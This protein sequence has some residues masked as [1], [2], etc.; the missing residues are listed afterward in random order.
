MVERLGLW[1]MG[2]FNGQRLA[3]GIRVFGV[4]KSLGFQ[5][6]GNGLKGF[7]GGSGSRVFIRADK[8]M[9]WGL[10]CGRLGPTGFEQRGVR[11]RF[12]CVGSGMH[13]IAPNHELHV[14]LALLYWP[15]P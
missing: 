3:L 11:C 10:G 4:G 13:L 9:C 7:S 5:V 12:R 14:S 1:A 2:W 6:Y 8:V 15:N